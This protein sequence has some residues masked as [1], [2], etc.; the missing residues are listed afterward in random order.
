MDQ[1]F[2]SELVA[3]RFEI[4][5]ETRRLC[6]NRLRGGSALISEAPKNPL[7]ELA[8]CPAEVL[9]ATPTDLPSR[10]PGRLKRHRC[11]LRCFQIPRFAHACQERTQAVSPPL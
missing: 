4:K 7:V 8:L 2:R 10:D 11:G 6:P 3:R 9:A 5:P 1:V